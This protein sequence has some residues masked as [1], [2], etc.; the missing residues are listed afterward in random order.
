MSMNDDGRLKKSVDSARE[1]RGAGDRA[2]TEN[3]SLSDD[4]RLE[5][6]RAQFFNAALP[7]LPKIPG[8]HVCWLSTT[9][10]RDTVMGRL[11]LGYELIKS[12]DV[13]GYEA[14]TLRTGEYVGCIGVNEMIAS[15]LSE[16]LY[17][18]YMSEAHHDAPAREAGKLTESVRL[19]QE[20]ARRRGGDLEVGDGLE[21]MGAERPAPVFAT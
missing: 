21:E 6:F 11:R 1:S 20:Q 9:N 18:R 8:Y 13:P 3:R 17:Q 15:K 12:E 2:A 16:S 4:D 19:M 14:V 7:D 5:M 10:P